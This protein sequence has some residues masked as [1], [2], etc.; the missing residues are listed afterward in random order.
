MR[1]RGLVESNCPLRFGCNESTHGICSL[2]DVGRWAC[3]EDEDACVVSLRGRGERVLDDGG[4]D[5]L[6]VGG[7]KRNGSGAVSSIGCDM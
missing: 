5:V 2:C 3:D 1:F 6:E 7:V 4:C